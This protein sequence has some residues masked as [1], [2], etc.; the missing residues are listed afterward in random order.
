MSKV[1]CGYSIMQDIKFLQT[2]KITN[3]IF[4]QRIKLHDQFWLHASLQDV[5]LKISH[6][7]GN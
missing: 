7:P 5:V 1:L 4:W 2:P 6:L 3:P